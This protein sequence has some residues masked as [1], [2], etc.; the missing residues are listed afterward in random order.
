MVNAN[1]G[2]IID[3][4]AIETLKSTRRRSCFYG[5]CRRFDCCYHAGD[6]N[7]WHW[8]EESKQFNDMIKAQPYTSEIDKIKDVSIDIGFIPVDPRL[9]DNY[10]LAIDYLMRSLDVKHAF[11]MHFWQDYRIFDALFD[12][13]S[14]EDYRENIERITNPGQV[15]EYE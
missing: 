1:K 2:Y 6:L 4:I 8:Y 9:E 7:W 5:A 10:I 13:E 12:D 11:P 3:G 14:T 15:F